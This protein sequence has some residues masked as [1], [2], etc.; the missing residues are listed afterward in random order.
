MEKLPQYKERVRS[1]ML[2]EAQQPF[3]WG[4]RDCALFAA[5]VLDALFGT[6]FYERFV[7]SYQSG[8]TA[9]LKVYRHGG[10]KDF[11]TKVVGVKPVEIDAN[12]LPRDGDLVFMRIDKAVTPWPACVGIYLNQRVLLKTQ[13]GVMETRFNDCLCYWRL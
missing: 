10:F 12:T 6:H 11:V 5:G 7:G 8:K 9:L 1:Y 2:R 4:K 3:E 13:S